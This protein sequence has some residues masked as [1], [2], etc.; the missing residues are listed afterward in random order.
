MTEKELKKIYVSNLKTIRIETGLSQSELSEQISITEKYYNTIENG[1]KWGSFATLVK[2]A[3]ALN[4]EPYEL[5]IP[6]TSLGKTL[7]KN[8]TQVLMKQLRNNLNELVN[9]VERFL[10]E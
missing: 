7:D 9:T 2:L 10:A 3:N 6:N 1:K 4:V 8:R 5:L